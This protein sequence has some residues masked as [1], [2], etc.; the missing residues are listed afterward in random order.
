MRLAVHTQPV[1]QD[2]GGCLLDD[3][4]CWKLLGSSQAISVKELEQCHHSSE[5]SSLAE[6]ASL[7]IGLLSGLGWEITSPLTLGISFDLLIFGA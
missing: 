7:E 2:H 3:F 5:S 4:I 1:N 6:M